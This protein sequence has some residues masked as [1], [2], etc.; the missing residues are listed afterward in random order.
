MKKN[1]A[2]NGL[3]LFELLL[4]ISIIA[5]LTSL[6]L[7]YC[8]DLQ[9]RIESKRLVN[10][11]ENALAQSRHHAFAH[12]QQ[13]V[14]CSSTDGS[15]CSEQ[16]WSKGF[17]IFNNKMQNSKRDANEKILQ[18]VELNLKHGTLEWKGFGSNNS[19]TF[20]SDTGLPR[21]SNGSFFYCSEHTN[22]SRKIILSYMGHHRVESTNC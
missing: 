8:T 16:Q 10:A 22:S 15:S 1:N 2:I 4:A 17:I 21:G 12:H 3:S 19:I 18:S 7:P 9:A 20:Q 6:A 11:I 5:I 14:I 13:I